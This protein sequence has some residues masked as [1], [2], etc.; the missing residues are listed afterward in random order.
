VRRGEIPKASGGTR[1]RGIPTVLDR[2]VRQAMLQV[3]QADWDP[4]FSDAS[5]GRRRYAPENGKK[6]EVTPIR[7]VAGREK[8]SFAGYRLAPGRA[9]RREL[10][11]AD[12][13]RR[14]DDRPRKRIFR[15]DA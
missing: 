4:S 13:A 11:R 6:V 9:R 7:F 12:V 2:F 1:A 5:F 15:S 10:P 8:R 3:M 14:D